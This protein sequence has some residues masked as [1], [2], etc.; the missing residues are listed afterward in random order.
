MDN[1]NNHNQHNHILYIYI[2]IYYYTSFMAYQ[3]MNP[4]YQAHDVTGQTPP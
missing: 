4:V 3:L 2:Y 1:N